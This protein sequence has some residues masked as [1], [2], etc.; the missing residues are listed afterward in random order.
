MHRQFASYKIE[1]ILH[2]QYDIN[3]KYLLPPVLRE[4]DSDTLTK[5]DHFLPLELFDNEDYDTR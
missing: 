5:D 1:D 2:E 3:L 4:D